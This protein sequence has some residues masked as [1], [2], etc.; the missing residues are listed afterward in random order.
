M[1]VE[2]FVHR[3]THDAH[4]DENDEV[5]KGRDLHTSTTNSSVWLV[6]D[7]NGTQTQ[8][9]KPAD[10]KIET[11]VESPATTT[12]N[13]PPAFQHGHSHNVQQ[14]DNELSARSVILLVALSLD[15]IFEGKTM[16]DKL[17]YN[18]NEKFDGKLTRF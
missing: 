15:C 14:F 8:T 18:S 1:F 9:T 6:P 5:E 17:L 11:S 2:Q 10:V 16:I 3:Y 13:V 7:N 12:S 4:G